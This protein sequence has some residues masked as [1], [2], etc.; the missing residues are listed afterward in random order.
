MPD[1]TCYWSTSSLLCLLAN[2]PRNSKV[3]THLMVSIKCVARLL[4]RAGLK[5]KLSNGPRKPAIAKINVTFSGMRC[6]TNGHAAPQ[7]CSNPTCTAWK[8]RWAKVMPRRSPLGPAT[9][10]PTR[11][12]RQFSRFSFKNLDHLKTI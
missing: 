8:A 9:A 3:K 7:T 5:G 12:Q 11:E 6:I 2:R 4:E 10:S 1:A